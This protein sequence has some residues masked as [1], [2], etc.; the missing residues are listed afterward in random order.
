[1]VRSL[2]H[3]LIELFIFLLLNFKCSSYIL[4]NS[5]LSDYLLQLFSSR[6]VCLFILLI[7]SFTEHKI[8]ILMES[9]LS[10]ISLMD[11]GIGAVLNISSPYL[12]INGHLD[13]L[14]NYL[15]GVL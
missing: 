10:I 9:S 5:L 11:C 6:L 12:N 14:L 15:P 2:A 13:F 1:M 7:V 4:D 8:F 3:L